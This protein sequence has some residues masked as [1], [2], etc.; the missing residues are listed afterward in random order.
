MKNG[1]ANQALLLILLQC[2]ICL[3]HSS[4]SDSQYSSNDSQNE[5]IE[6]NVVKWVDCDY[7]NGYGY[8]TNTCSSCNGSGKIKVNSYFQSQTRTCK[9]CA[10]IGIQ[11]CR[12]CDHSGKSVC[13]S[14]KGERYYTCP[15]C[16][17]TGIL[18]GWSEA[19]YYCK[20]VGLIFCITCEGKGIV[21]CSSCYGRGELRCIVCG[22]S[23]GPSHSY[24]R[25]EIADCYSCSGSGRVNI[26]CSE[27]DGKGKKEVLDD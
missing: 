15:Q 5:D 2:L 11:P 4:C 16:Y 24:E 1:F 25:T 18:E 10:G 8:F 13:R 22:G 17:G 7:C 20:G 14:C 21:R 26:T 23:G 19:C 6:E 9:A 3:V 12:L 27:C